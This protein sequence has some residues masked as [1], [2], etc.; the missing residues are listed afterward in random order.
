MGEKSITEGGHMEGLCSPRNGAMLLCHS[1][2]EV[3]GSEEIL[4]EKNV[5]K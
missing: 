2:S 1:L 4:K 5:C 3:K